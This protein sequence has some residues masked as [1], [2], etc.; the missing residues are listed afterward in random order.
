MKQSLRGRTIFGFLWLS[1][2]KMS[3]AVIQLLILGILARLLGP[4]EFGLI[5]LALIA[6]SFSDIFIDMGFGPAI[7]QKKELSIVDIHTSFTS[8]LLF[9]CFLLLLLWL[10][11]PFVALF[12]GNEEL[13]PILRTLSWVLLFKS[14]ATTPLGLL[15]RDLQFKL[16]SVTQIICYVVGYGAVG[17]VLAYLDFGVWSL[18]Y[19]N[20]AQALL[21]AVIFVFICRRKL[22]LFISY[23][24]FKALLHFGGGY[25]LSKIFTYFGNK[26]DKLVVGR[27]LGVGA[28][29]IYERGYQ[30]VRFI[31]G[32]I[33]EVIDKVLFSPLAKKQDDRQLVGRIFIEITYLISIILFPAS[34]YIFVNAEELVL[35][36]LGKNW[37]E[38][39][40]I[41]KL[42][43]F[44]LFFLVSTRVGSTLAKSLGDVYNRAL[45]SFLYA[46][47]VIIGSIIASSQGIEGVAVAVGL[48]IALNYMLAFTQTKRLTGVKFSTFVEAHLLGIM[49]SIIFYGISNFLGAIIHQN[50]P[51]ASLLMNSVA[52]TGAYA[53]IPLLDHK[54]LLK[55]YINTLKHKN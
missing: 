22:K 3:H 38:T 15:Y 45:R 10:M 30:L 11:S 34:I 19:A 5:G 40:I 25:S 26:G 2:V 39:I 6:V 28:L 37:T 14:S 21:S 20:L 32:L 55:K 17:V 1:G 24:S 9:G 31:A 29:G 49:L 51:L 18:V 33:G 36:I 53:L 12:F 50:S 8:S 46:I 42:M 43:S 47:C 7:T 13:T 16:L 41:V 35:I 23:E 44:S 54:R 48:A 52:L 4:S 27:L